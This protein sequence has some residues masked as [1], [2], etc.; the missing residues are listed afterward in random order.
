MVIHNPIL[1]GSFTVNNIDVSSITSSAANITALNATTASLNSFSASVLSYTASQ[2]I[3][4]GTYTLTSSFNAQTASFTAFTASILAQTASLNSFSASILSYT[5]SLN[6]KTASFA[7]T[8]SNTFIGSQVISGSLTTSGS[9]TSTS[10]ITAQT[11]V[12]Q[13]ITSSVV[14]SSGSNVFGNALTN[15][16]VFSGSVSM[17]PGGLFISGSGL[18]G[19]GTTTP[20]QPLQVYSN[21]SSS[22]NVT[23]EFWNG[24][25]G[26]GTRNFIRLRNSSTISSTTSAYFGQGQDQK[27]YFY[28]NDTS[29]PGDIVIT[30]TGKV[31]IGT[32]SPIAQLHVK[33]DVAS[34]NRP[35]TLTT[36]ATNSAAFI[37]TIDGSNAGIA[38]GQLGA[39][40][41][42]IQST[43]QDGSACTP[44]ILNPYSG[45]VGI[46]TGNTAPGGALDVVTCSNS[47]QNFYLRN[48]NN[49]DASSRAYFNIVAGNTSLSLLAL[50]GGGSCGGTYIAGTCGADMY[51]QQQ[52]GGAVNM[53]IKSDGKVGIGTASP[54]TQLEIKGTN[55][56][57]KIAACFF[58]TYN[59]GF[60]FSDYNAGITYDAGGNTM[61]LYSNYT[62]YGGI[63]LST[64]GSPRLVVGVG[65]CVGINNTV[66][67]AALEIN[68]ACSD[69]NYGGFMFKTIDL[70]D[71]T[72]T[73]F[74]TPPAN[75][76]GLATLSWVGTNDHNRSGAAQIRWS[77]QPCAAQLGPTTT[78]FNDSQ[79]AT[80]YFR[81]SGGNMQI[82]VD[83]AGAGKRLQIMIM[84]SR[85][86]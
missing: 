19:I 75:W 69:Q 24:D 3:L 63:V 62:G 37:T 45:N 26:T 22:L 13:T 65:A 80:G 7:T 10:T 49:L 43:Y 85:G 20:S 55:T 59:A 58:S 31:G 47:T 21:I 15:T 71:N 61:C 14:Y 28:N 54:S 38:F 5:S 77:Y 84:G 76:G 41:N 82:C 2:N 57:H 34:G 60:A 16:Q 51:F 35:T 74:F 86:A 42:Y 9:I 53:I 68:Q 33:T 56:Y 23:A 4:N 66:P 32:A 73:T 18:V 67:R 46:G 70:P 50:A 25:Y 27:T 36:S 30:N 72:W 44:L 29:R 52:A 48:T 64:C 83:G 1:T 81:Y 78:I 8:G 12:V 17:N 11:L 40:S 6:A 79:N 39:N